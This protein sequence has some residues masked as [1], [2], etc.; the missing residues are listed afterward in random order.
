[1]SSPSK[2]SLGNFWIS[3]I[4]NALHYQARCDDLGDIV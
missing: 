3:L 2:T 4:T 1:M